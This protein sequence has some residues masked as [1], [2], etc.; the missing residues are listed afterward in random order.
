LRKLSAK[1]FLLLILVLCSSA[2]FGQSTL[3]GNTPTLPKTQRDTS[4]SNT[5]QWRDEEARITYQKLNSAKTYIPDTSIHTFHRQPFTQPGYRDMGNLGSPVTN[6][7]F[8]PEYRVGPTLGYHVFDVY[9]FFVDSAN[10][11]NT[12]RPYSIFN[13]QL[14]SKLEQIAGILHTQNITPTWNFCF[15][16]HKINS[17]GFYKIQ[18]NNHD[19][20][21]FTTN[22][23]S[24]DQ[25]YTIYA[26]VVY[27]KEQHDENGGMPIDTQLTSPYYIDRRTIDVA[28]QHDAYSLTRSSVTNMQRD[29]TMLIQH[30]YMWGRP[31]TTY[32][33]DSTQFTARLIP[34]FSVT[35]KLQLSTEK[36][37][38]KDFNPDSLRYTTLFNQSFG[39]T[40]NLAGGDSVQTD[41]KW[42]WIDN[43]FLINGF[44]GKPDDQL[45]FSAGLGNRVDEFFSS[46][47]FHLIHNPPTFW[48]YYV[49]QDKVNILSNYM[50]GEIKKEALR[51]G[52]WEY[53]ANTKFFLTGDYAG[54]FVLNALIGKELKNNWGN[55]AAGFQQQLNAAPFNYTTYENLYTRLSFNFNNESVTAVYG[56]LDNPRLHISGGLRNYVIANYIYLN[57][58]ELPAQYNVP[59]SITQAW[60]RKVFKFGYFFLDNEVVY[61]KIP[62]NAPVNV[63]SLMGK[64][65][66]SFEK[67]MFHSPLKIALGIELRYNTAYYVPGYDALL[68]RFFYQKSSYI[69][70]APEEA[71][72]LNFRIKR[73][74]AFLMGDNLQTL[75]GN[76]NTILYTG[77]PVYN[78]GQ[79]QVSS[80]PRYAAPDVVIRFGFSW[81]L[82]N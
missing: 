48:F 5:S 25:H 29:F 79:D 32:N 72:F 40:G 13:Y 74:R 82:I 49:G 73:F 14:G 43:Q 11:Y 81:S 51:A 10:F 19:N 15:E 3:P 47:V 67:R 7:L 33:A 24:P 17:P 39:T 8:T 65:Q 34:R 21:C 77:T 41:Q 16:Y 60:A 63:P 71:V 53:G 78:F 22:Y 64:H 69:T 80:I 1:Y 61:Q 68:N 66:L 59:F 55:F 44:I 42:F 27:N 57:E 37:E 62:D 35:H 12:T 50:T 23:K 6:M 56:T 20:G 38:Y 30:S 75:F 46:P 4:K 45:K 18:R 76:H 58:N 54:R 70:N 26:A 9:R 36:H 52:E 28:Y 31:D 2:G